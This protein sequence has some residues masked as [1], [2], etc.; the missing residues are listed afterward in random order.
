MSNFGSV[1]IATTIFLFFYFSVIFSF[2][3]FCS[4]LYV[5]LS[6]DSEHRHL[7]KGKCSGEDSFSF[8][9]GVQLL[10]LG[11]YTDEWVLSEANGNLSNSSHM[12]VCVCWFVCKLCGCATLCENVTHWIRSTHTIYDDSTDE[13]LT[14]WCIY[15]QHQ[16]LY[17]IKVHGHSVRFEKE[18]CSTQ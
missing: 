10:F 7:S 15:S 8:S 17:H 14:N 6:I 11:H 13:F 2:F 1:L 18:R 5:L 4:I 16:W 12:C 3:L 9:G